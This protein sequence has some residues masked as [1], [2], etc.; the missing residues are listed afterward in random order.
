MI[1]MRATTRE[2]S[3]T[4]FFIFWKGKELFNLNI[5][6][7]SQLAFVRCL[8]K[9][10]LWSNLSEWKHIKKTNRVWTHLNIRAGKENIPWDHECVP[11]YA[12]HLMFAF[13]KSSRRFPHRD[14]KE[15]W[16][17]LNPPS[18]HDT[19]AWKRKM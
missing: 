13:K 10:Q 19:F 15:T 2:N 5:F 16:T 11:H 17:K 8:K 6:I 4:T 9:D 18:N 1:M 14:E 7:I 12:L 3:L